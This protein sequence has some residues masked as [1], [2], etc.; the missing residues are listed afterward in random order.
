MSL[1]SS[2]GRSCHSQSVLQGSPRWAELGLGGRHAED[3]VSEVPQLELIKL[4]TR[5]VGKNALHPPLLHIVFVLHREHFG[6]KAEHVE[7]RVDMRFGREVE[8]SAHMTVARAYICHCRC[9]EAMHSLFHVAFC[10]HAG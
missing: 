6:A 5:L 7:E 8:P 3:D 4:C 2:S 10:V 1:G 9:V